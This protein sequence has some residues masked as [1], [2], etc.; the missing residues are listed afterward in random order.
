VR[1]VF[2]VPTG[3]GAP[4]EELAGAL[5]DEAVRRG[6]DATRSTRFD[7]GPE[8]SY[9]LVAPHGQRRGDPLPGARTRARS[10]V[11]C[12]AP[13]GSVDFDRGEA[14]GRRMGSVFDINPNGVAELRRRGVAA[15]HLQLGYSPAWVAEPPVDHRDID[16]L[17][18]GVATERRLRLL[19]RLAGDLAPYRF[20]IRLTDVIEPVSSPATVVTGAD[21]WHLLARSKLFL[22]LAPSEQP[23]A[24]W[25]RLAQAV[26]AGCVVLAEDGPQY[27]PLQP[28]RDLVTGPAR[29]LGRLARDL[30]TD[31]GAIG[32]L[33]AGVARLAEEGPSLAVA[34][35]E[36]VQCLRR[37]AE[38][39]PAAFAVRQAVAEASP[40]R[41]RARVRH[42]LP[43]LAARSRHVA[44]RIV[45]RTVIESQQ[46]SDA[47]VATLLAGLKDVRLDLIELR[48]QVACLSSPDSLA[49]D[50]TEHVTP[51]FQSAT[52]RISIVVS[53]FNYEECIVEA[54]D[55]TI[56]AGGGSTEVVVVDDASSDGSAECARA[57]FERHPDVAGCLI[58]RSANRGLPSARNLGLGRARGPMAFILD[59]DNIIAPGGI[60]LLAQ[61]LDGDPMAAFAYGILQSFDSDG[62]LGL[63]SFYPWDA[64]LLKHGNYIDAMALVRTTALLE[65]GGYSTD[66]RLHGIEDYDLW[67]R[68]AAAG[69]HAAF[70]PEVVGRYRVSLGSM[71]RSVT[72]ISTDVAESIIDDRC[73]H[74]ARR[75]N[76]R[77]AESE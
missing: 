70:V 25:V 40:P 12:T 24:D 6:I 55:S 9:V 18:V 69:A 52:P 10:A 57:W 56:T 71:L 31:D 47:K 49:D 2:V 37:S 21:R 20:M 38:V 8:P 16:L 1:V 48:R 65:L 23:E 62:P 13:V 3:A 43:A 44:E 28:G 32:R 41:V 11:I 51:A 22:E 27:A 46:E 72:S 34:V 50:V 17:F 36:I 66:R 30:L 77:N 68:L 73:A 5:C 53:L 75:H 29:W 45:V 74:V 42:S 26:S 63:V 60:D 54:L 61:A 19:G 35:D 64:E 33:R 7:A 15:R 4:A 39:T 59:A 14:I 58:R 67:R 76:P